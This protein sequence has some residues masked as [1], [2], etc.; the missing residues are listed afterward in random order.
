MTVEGFSNA[1][2]QVQTVYRS[3]DG[4]AHWYAVTANLPL[5]PVSG[6]VVDPQSAATAYLATD[7]GVFFT[8]QVST[9]ANLP[10]TCWS[11]FGTG[12]FPRLLW[13]A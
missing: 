7:A 10:S 13:W 12:P 3:T 2:E 4:G 9:C 6:L 8:T 5:V 11:A 1:L